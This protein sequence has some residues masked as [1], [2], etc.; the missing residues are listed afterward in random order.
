VQAE[1]ATTAEEFNSL[2]AEAMAA[3]GP[4]LIDALVPT[5]FG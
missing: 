1:R 4:R 2:F 3:K 5:L